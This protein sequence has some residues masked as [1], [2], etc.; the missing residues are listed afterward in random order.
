ME[1]ASDSRRNPSVGITVSFHS[2]VTQFRRVD[3]TGVMSLAAFTALIGLII[4]L[5]HLDPLTAPNA[6]LAIAAAA[7]AVGVPNMWRDAAP[8]TRR[9]RPIPRIMVSR[10]EALIIGLVLAGRRSPFLVSPHCQ[11]SSTYRLSDLV[12]SWCAWYR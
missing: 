6:I 7:G 8:M 9:L 4:A 5:V 11:G 10:A 3:E 1:Q 2:A 12:T